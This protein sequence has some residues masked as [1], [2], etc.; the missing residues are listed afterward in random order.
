MA[1]RR[2]KSSQVQEGSRVSNLVRKVL[3]YVAL[4]A[5]APRACRSIAAVSAGARNQV[6]EIVG[7]ELMEDL[8]EVAGEAADKVK[9]R[10]KEKLRGALKAGV[11]T[12]R[13]K[14][15]ALDEEDD[16]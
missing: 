5:L 15:A 3:P 8:G 12:T 11:E 14:L 13:E 7:E 9:E 16:K 2:A 1:K 4:I 10:S 6:E